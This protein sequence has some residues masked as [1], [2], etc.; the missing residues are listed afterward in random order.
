MNPCPADGVL[1]SFLTEDGLSEAQAA[2]V[3]Q[4][5][6][7]CE[8]CQRVLEQLTGDFSRPSSRDGVAAGS[9][10]W[11]GADR[12]ALAGYEVLEEIARSG[13][14]VVYRAR[15]TTDDHVVAIKVL[16]GSGKDLMRFAAEMQAGE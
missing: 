10:G 6:V 7:D 14:A 5:V 1:G 16:T 15:N 2:E 4:H 11:P 8:R 9:L 13:S 3:E 12:F